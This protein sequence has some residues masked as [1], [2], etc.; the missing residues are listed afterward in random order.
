M[1]YR[2]SL[3][4]A[5]G[6]GS[7]KEGIEHWWV[8][9]LT[10][11]ALVPLS[12]WFAFSVVTLVGGD[13]ETY[14]A[15]AGEHGNAMLLVLL[16]ICL[17]HHAQLGVQVIIEDYVHHEGIKVASI[18][19]TKFTAVFFGASSVAAVLRITFGG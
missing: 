4:K 15:W 16:V 2:S 11:L 17:F 10:A 6:L 18:I 5:R 9:R 19:A 7:A 14:R 1:Q 13:Y 3:S 8:L 12:L